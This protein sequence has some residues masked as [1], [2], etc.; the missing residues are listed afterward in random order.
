MRLHFLLNELHNIAEFRGSYC[1]S[2]L[3]QESTSSHYHAYMMHNLPNSMPG[4]KC[5][6]GPANEN[7][8]AGLEPPPNS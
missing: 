2:H 8:S 3:L 5:E 4:L 1:N 6:P 7:G